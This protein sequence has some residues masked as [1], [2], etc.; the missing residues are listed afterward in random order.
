MVHG[1]NPGPAP[2]LTKDEESE[3]FEYLQS[4]AKIGC[5]KTRQQ[6]MN[7]VERVAKEKGLLKRERITSGWF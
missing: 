6:V 5:G 7:I 2:Y 4:T 1:S 3:L